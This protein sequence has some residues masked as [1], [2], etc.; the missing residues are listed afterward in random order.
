MPRGILIPSDKLQPLEVRDFDT[1]FDLQVGV[2]GLIDVI[3]IDR[4]E[5]TLMLNKER[6]LFGV[7]VNMRATLLLEVHNTRYRG[8]PGLLGDAVLVGRSD[9]MGG[10]LDVP[11]FLVHLLTATDQYQVL[12][13]RVEDLSWRIHDHVFTDWQTAYASV[14]RH[15]MK[16][17]LVNHVQV[18]PARV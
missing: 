11:G 3:D 8:R 5:A 15:A 16:D 2:G 9:D 1:M 13:Q 6:T 7:E 17:A 10:L 18:I 4:P 12:Q 14:L